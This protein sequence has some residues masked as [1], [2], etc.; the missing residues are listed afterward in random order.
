LP[1]L[2]ENASVVTAAGATAGTG[3][4]APMSWRHAACEK[5]GGMP[6]PETLRHDVAAGPP[7][8]AV[9]AANAVSKR[10]LSHEV[11]TRVS[12]A[13]HRREVLCV[14]GP[15]GSGKTTLLRC[16]NSRRRGT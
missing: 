15:S 3:A 6:N 11:L 5:L 9:I 4:G 12:L 14:V 2:G 7:G 16:S 10:F 13:V 8:V 1:A